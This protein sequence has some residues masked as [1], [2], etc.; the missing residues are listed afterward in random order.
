MAKT[1]DFLFRVGL[2][3]KGV[4][5]LFEILGGVLL[6]MPTRL[7]GYIG[8]LS[9]HELYKHPALSG[10]LDHLADSVTLHASMGEA[11]YLMVHGLAKVILI[12]AIFRE[13]RWGYLG[14][15]GVLSLF[16]AIEV[17]RAV[18]HHEIV[19]GALAAFDLFVVV[20]IYKEYVQRYAWK[21]E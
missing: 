16:T 13:K 12:S 8:L 3:V 1:T 6:M 19:T 21:G 9:Q 20:L 15:M 2:I 10:K 11:A 5:S 14:L 4:D 18:T 17:F 7:A